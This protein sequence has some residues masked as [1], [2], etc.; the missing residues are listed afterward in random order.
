LTDTLHRLQVA[1]EAG[2]AAE[3]LAIV[4]SLVPEYKPSD[5]AGLP[6][7]VLEPVTI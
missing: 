3:A 2:N 5:T 6:V 1:C 4:R 7:A